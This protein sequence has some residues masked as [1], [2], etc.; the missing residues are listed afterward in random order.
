[1]AVALI[2]TSPPA[3]VIVFH[4]VPTELRLPNGN[5]VAGATVGWTNGECALVAVAPFIAPSGKVVSGPASYSFDVNGNVVETCNVIDVVAPQLTASGFR[6]LFTPAEKA[7]ITAA[8]AS[9]VNVRVFMDDADAA[10]AIDLK[11]AAVAQ[12]IG[13][14]VAKGLL[15]QDRATVVLA[16]TQPQ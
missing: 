11:S 8:G 15:T 16:G 1:M 5:R 4:D 6:A 10:D 2:T 9:D 14:L 13:Y 7:A 12:G 3:V